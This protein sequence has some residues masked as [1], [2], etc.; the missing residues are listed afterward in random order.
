MAKRKKKSL[1]ERL[2]DTAYCDDECEGRCSDCPA[3]VS[4]EAAATIR[5]LQARVKEL[6]EGLRP[7]AKEAELWADSVPDDYRPLCTEPGH[8]TPC[9][10]SESAYTVGDTRR[11]RALVEDK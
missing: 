11:A 6:E 7:F 5:T 8:K 10:G 9:P 2:E 3:Q 4:R 1:P